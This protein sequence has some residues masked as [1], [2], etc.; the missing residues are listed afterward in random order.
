M[1]SDR[2]KLSLKICAALW[3]GGLVVS[4][5]WTRSQPG[6]FHALNL[7]GIADIFC[8][9]AIVIGLILAVRTAQRKRSAARTTPLLL[10][11]TIVGSNLS[12][13][14]RAAAIVASD[15]VADQFDQLARRNGGE[16]PSGSSI[17]FATDDFV[18]GYSVGVATRHFQANGR[19]PHEMPMEL[20]ISEL[21]KRL[22]SLLPSLDV[23]SSYRGGSIRL[24]SG[25]CLGMTEHGEKRNGMV[26]MLESMSPFELAP[27]VIMRQF[28]FERGADPQQA[29]M[30]EAACEEMRA[31]YAGG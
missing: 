24:T 21:Q 9:I 3:I 7:R 23:E 25:I 27:G 14:T 13:L 22:N 12:I 8:G 11:A 6:S 31:R 19:A 18:V 26:R 2:L 17:R 4:E 15:A 16:R 29:Y 28:A 20:L 30:V 5:V 10:N 1:Q